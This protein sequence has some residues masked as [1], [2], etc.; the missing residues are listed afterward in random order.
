M[1]QPPTNTGSHTRSNYYGNPQFD[2][3]PVIYVDWNMATT[4]CQW[5]GRRL[6]TEAEWEMAARGTDGRIYPWGNSADCSLANCC[7][8]G[9]GIGKCV[10]DTTKV[11]TY[12]NG[13]SPYGAYDMSGN[14]W[15]WVYDLYSSDYSGTLSDDIHNPQGPSSG[16]YRVLRGGAWYYYDP[17]VRSTT[18]FYED[19]SYSNDSIGFRCAQ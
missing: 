12:Q 11:G 15:Q 1:C 16:G 10:G 13:A 5:A 2:D 17:Y 18:R 6:P 7:G 4:Y 19:P 8:K 9:N 3:Y 14:V